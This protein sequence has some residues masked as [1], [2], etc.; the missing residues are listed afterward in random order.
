MVVGKVGKIDLEYQARNRIVLDPFQR[1]IG[2]TTEFGCSNGDFV[3]ARACLALRQVWCV[4]PYLDTSHHV[5][6]RNETD[7]DV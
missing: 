7:I 5:V 3:V 1:N 2:E 6:H 4:R